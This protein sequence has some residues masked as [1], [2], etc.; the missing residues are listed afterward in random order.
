MPIDVG[1]F[2]AFITE[3]ESDAPFKQ[4]YLFLAFPHDTFTSITANADI[5]LEEIDYLFSDNSDTPLAFVCHSR[6]GLLARKVAAALYGTGPERWKQQLVGCVTFGTPHQGTPLAEYPRKLLGAGVAA[7]RAIQA[8]GFM[9]ASDVLALVEAY[10]NCNTIP[11]IDDLKPPTAIG[12]GAQST[13]FVTDL[14]QAER[15]VAEQH[16]CRL[17]VLAIGGRG[18]HDSRLG[19]ITGKMFRGIPHDCAVELS[20]S[21]PERVVGITRQEVRSDHFS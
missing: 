20:S 5:L 6:G 4:R 3:L 7:I 21:A 16:K 10:S 2:D 1:L 17:Q 8:G 13:T 12:K 18:P 19:R 11:G 15:A 14:R 9:G